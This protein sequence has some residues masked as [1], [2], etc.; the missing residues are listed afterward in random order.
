MHSF[1][2]LKPRI[3][4]FVLAMLSLVG[5]CVSVD[6]VDRAVNDPSR[7]AITPPSGV[8]FD[9][10]K[11]YA[12]IELASRSER[13][14]KRIYCDMQGTRTY[15]L[16]RTFLAGE[17]QG[18]RSFVAGTFDGSPLF[19]A[20]RTQV[21]NGALLAVY[22][23]ETPMEGQFAAVATSVNAN[24]PLR[25]FADLRPV[26]QFSR[27]AINLWRA[28]R[29]ARPDFGRRFYRL[30]R[31]RVSGSLA[32]FCAPSSLPATA[33]GLHPHVASVRTAG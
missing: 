2:F 30:S 13:T 17:C 18:G 15:S 1:Q 32:R 23:I 27:G 3:T 21:A 26:H 12:V 6:A 11:T 16:R 19:S 24:L 29:T 20:V 9:P 5:A 33:T 31:E 25:I 28:D 10:G 22:E 8:T 14:G 4:L 7:I